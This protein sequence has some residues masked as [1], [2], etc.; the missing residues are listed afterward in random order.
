MPVNDSN[1]PLE[2]I[3]SF[4]FSKKFVQ[5]IAID[6]EGIMYG[7]TNT[8]E[9]N[10]LKGMFVLVIKNASAPPKPTA[11]KHASADIRTE[12]PNGIQKKF[13]EYSGT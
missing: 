10:F 5:N 4:E 9:T 12:R 2:P 6:H 13:C 1:K 3:G 7:K 11:I 8:V